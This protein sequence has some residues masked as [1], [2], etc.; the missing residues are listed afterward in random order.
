MAAAD[1]PNT[2][3]LQAEDHADDNDSALG[4]DMSTYT[5]TLRSSLLE[6]VKENGRDYHTYHDGSYIM[7]EDEQEQ[8]RLDMQH[9]IFL[10]TFDRKLILAPIPAEQKNVRKCSAHAILQS[11]DTTLLIELFRQSRPWHWYRTLG[12]RLCG[13]A[14]RSRSARHRPKPNSTDMGPAELQVRSYRFRGP[15]DLSSQI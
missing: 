13:H 12:Y 10:R 7:P 3:V 1:A 5:E 8:E 4:S 14:P 9:E 11:L 6:S 2:D 15:M